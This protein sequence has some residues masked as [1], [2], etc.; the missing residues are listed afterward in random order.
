MENIH[1]ALWRNYNELYHMRN[2][3]GWECWTIVSLSNCYSSSPVH[4]ND[5]TITFVDGEEKQYR[6]P[7]ITFIRRHMLHANLFFVFG[8]KKDRT[9]T[10][11]NRDITFLLVLLLRFQRF[12]TKRWRAVI[13]VL[14]NSYSTALPIFLKY[15]Q[16]YYTFTIRY[17]QNS[18][19]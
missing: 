17:F 1:R 18:F 19:F 10:K 14:H 12:P 6:M 9:P 3:Q 5:R 15:F 7:T 2:I 11:F 16:N 4:V 8:S 13:Q